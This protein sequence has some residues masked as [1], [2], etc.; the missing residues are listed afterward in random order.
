M[1]LRL[2]Y[3]PPLAWDEL[4]AYLAARAIPGVE[5]VDGR[6]YRRTLRAGGRPLVVELEHAAP[7]VTLTLPAASA[8][9]SGAIVETARRGDAA[10]EIV[11]GLEIGDTILL[12]AAE[13]KVARITPTSPTSVAK[14]V[15]LTI[16]TRSAE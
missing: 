15:A 16:R 13:G 12:R 10:V 2:P 8:E 6:S 14:P 11:S 4:L 5:A 1:T 7:V 3:R 9:A